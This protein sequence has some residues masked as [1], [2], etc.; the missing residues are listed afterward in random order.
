MFCFYTIYMN[1][2]THNIA[3]RDF[4]LVSIKLF[5]T[6]RTYKEVP[7]ITSYMILKSFKHML[8]VLLW[9]GTAKPCANKRKIH[10]V[11][12]RQNFKSNTYLLTIRQRMYKLYDFYF[13]LLFNPYIMYKYR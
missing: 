9:L 5:S 6:R 3:Y 2:H 10:F 7:Y 1:T 8:F 11:V 12:P 4:V 13:S